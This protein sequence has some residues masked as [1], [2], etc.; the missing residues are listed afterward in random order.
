VSLRL[1]RKEDLREGLQRVAEQRL[2]QILQALDQDGLTPAAVHE[3][4]KNIKSLRA[5]LRLARGALA[6]ET[7]RRRNSTLRDVAA[8]LSAQRDAAVI[9]D[10]FVKVCRACLP[11]DEEPK[12]EPKWLREARQALE[13][14][15]QVVTKP[16]EL[17]M[18]AKRVKY[19]AGK[20]LPFKNQPEPDAGSSVHIDGWKDAVEV[21]LQ[22]TYKQGR[23]LLQATEKAVNQPQENWHEL[24]K[25]AKDLGYQLTLLEKLERVD[26]LVADLDKIG[27]A[28]GDARDLT[29]LQGYL[30]KRRGKRE[31]TPAD[32]RLCDRLFAYIEGR[33]NQ[34]QRQAL[35]LAR[36]VYG[37]SSRKFASRMTKRWQRWR[38]KSG[39][40]RLP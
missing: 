37:D 1:Q 35:R 15:A 39:K 26:K 31:L 12:P 14:E 36:R 13:K 21:G 4:R 16:D 28:L 23:Q 24:R 17:K 5:M 22:K 30:L 38:N 32:Q 9:L 3:A 20:F 10:A 27:S 40:S 29:L 18:V 7:R 34:L 8:K 2:R 11:S 33:R 19:L 25:K 6:E